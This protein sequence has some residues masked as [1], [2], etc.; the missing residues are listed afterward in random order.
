MKHLPGIILILFFLVEGEKAFTQ[1]N[2]KYCGWTFG[3]NFGLYYPS[4]YSAN[5]Y[6]GSDINENKASWVLGNYYWYQEIFK[7]LDIS[8]TVFVA[9]NGLPMNMHYKVALNPGIFGEYRF[10]KSYALSFEFNYLKLKANDAIGLEV[11][12]K[13][14]ATEPDIRLY[15]VKGIE[16]RVYFNLTLKRY[17]DSPKPNLNYFLMGGINVNNTK[18]LKNALYIEEKE[19]SM[20]NIYGRQN[21]VPNTSMQTFSVYEGGI[22]FGLVAGGGASLTFDNG[23]ILEPGITANWT[24]VNL[25]GYK[26]F[27]P[28]I[29]IYMRFILNS[30][31]FAE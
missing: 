7:A 26:R 25:E 15:P 13:E 24:R 27:T 23:I 10:N 29:G 19:Y 9:D 4:G 12:P 1:E 30:L 6:N 20:I 8:D 5:Y 17:F 21:Y 28:G 31:L 16:E 14:Y 11:D 22:G 18:V 3:L 2:D